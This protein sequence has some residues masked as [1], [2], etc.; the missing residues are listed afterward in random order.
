MKKSAVLDN[1]LE[2][3]VGATVRAPF[4]LESGVREATLTVQEKL[5]RHFE[6]DGQ[7]FATRLM[8]EVQH[9]VI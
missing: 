7:T 1:V 9:S 8:H 4:E 5:D 2:S 3:S 6:L